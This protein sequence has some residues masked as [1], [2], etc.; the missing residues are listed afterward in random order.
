MSQSR[1]KHPRI[2]PA[3]VMQALVIYVSIALPLLWFV[4]FERGIVQAAFVLLVLVLDLIL[5]L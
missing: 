1:T 2:R 3:A 5:V 4:H